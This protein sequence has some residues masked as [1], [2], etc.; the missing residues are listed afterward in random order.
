MKKLLQNVIFIHFVAVA[1]QYP[2]RAIVAN[3]TYYRDFFLFLLY[4]IFYIGITTRSLKGIKL[5]GLDLLVGCYIFYG[6]FFLVYGPCTN[7]DWHETIRLFRNYCAPM[8]LYFVA[9]YAFR[10]FKDVQRLLK[11]LFLITVVFMADILLE[12][13]WMS[14]LGKSGSSIPWYTFIYKTYAPLVQRLAKYPEL[15]LH[16]R[17]LF[18]IFGTVNFM[19]AILAAL[20]ALFIPILLDT[21]KRDFQGTTLLPFVYKLNQPTK[22]IIIFLLVASLLILQVKVHLVSLA[23]VMFLMLIMIGNTKRVVLISGIFGACFSFPQFREALKLAWNETFFVYRP[24]FGKTGAIRTLF[25]IENQIAYFNGLPF[26]EKI[27][28]DARFQREVVLGESRFFNFSF[29]FGLIWFVLFISLILVAV[30]YCFGLKGQRFWP[31][32]TKP[33][34]VGLIGLFIVFLIDM[35][36]YAFIMHFFAFDLFILSLAIAALLKERPNFNYSELK[37]V[38]STGL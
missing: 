20:T 13:S 3:I 24:A 23:V 8:G 38:E 36:H 28:G 17:C 37:C 21:E 7:N 34:R 31:A 30:R 1:F 9:R 19:A 26:I 4:V 32:Y 22:L 29:M 6:F 35:L 27:F 10:D 15:W 2:L 16:L 5:N 14:V 11:F 33:L 18:T 25:S 12:V